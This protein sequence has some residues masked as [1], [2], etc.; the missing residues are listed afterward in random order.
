MQIVAE[1][2]IQEA[3]CCMKYR[4]YKAEVGV[5]DVKTLDPPQQQQQKLVKNP[6]KRLDVFFGDKRNSS[7]E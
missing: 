5:I 7:T 1:I 4:E 2:S 3:V 6:S